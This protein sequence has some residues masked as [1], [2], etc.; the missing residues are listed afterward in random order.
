MQSLILLFLT[1]RLL[2]LVLL[3]LLLFLTLFSLV[4]AFFAPVVMLVVLVHFGLDLGARH[5]AHQLLVVTRHQLRRLAQ[6]CEAELDRQ[7]L[8]KCKQHKSLHNW[9]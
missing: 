3:F 4:L 2:F 7:A 1:T 5:H 9:H 8:C 6:I